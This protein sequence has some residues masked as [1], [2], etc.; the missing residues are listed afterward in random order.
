MA[1]TA[2][3]LSTQV[4]STQGTNEAYNEDVMK[5]VR[6]SNRQIRVGLHLNFSDFLFWL[7]SASLNL[8]HVMDTVRRDLQY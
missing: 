5:V 8:H 1:N 3:S 2:A 4:L 6:M 7:Y